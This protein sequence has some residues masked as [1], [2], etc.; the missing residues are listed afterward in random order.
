MNIKKIVALA[1]L[2]VAVGL[3]VTACYKTHGSSGDEDINRAQKTE[4]LKK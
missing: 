4:G 2:S 1:I 3:A